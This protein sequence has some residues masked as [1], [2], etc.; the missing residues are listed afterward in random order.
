MFASQESTPWYRSLTGLIAASVLLPPLGVVLLWTRRESATKAKIL[1]TLLIVVWGVGAF[2][3]L[4]TWRTSSLYDAH[5]AALEQHRAQQE[6]L[7]GSQQA[8]A[9]TNPQ[10]A[11]ATAPA[12]ASP[13]NPATAAAPGEPHPRPLT[14]QET[15][16]QISAVL[17]AM[18]VTMKWPC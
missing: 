12:T 7:A 2:Y 11:S 4:R 5:Y 10:T 8:V 9:P 3:M 6:A 1:G 13:A 18:A 17:T 14:L 15:I 16:G